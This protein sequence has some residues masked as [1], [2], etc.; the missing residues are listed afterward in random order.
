MYASRPVNNQ[1]QANQQAEPKTP[2]TSK[3]NKLDLTD[4]GKLDWLF[5]SSLNAHEQPGQT[6]I[7]EE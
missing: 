7:L 2:E 1:S 4:G 3:T 5:F 6:I